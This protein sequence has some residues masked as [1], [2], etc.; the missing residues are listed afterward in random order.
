MVQRPWAAD[1]PAIRAPAALDLSA[2]PQDNPTTQ[3]LLYGRGRNYQAL[4][5]IAGMLAL[6]GSTPRDAIF[7]SLS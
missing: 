1:E 3:H 5:S 4:M 7:D 2:L 6:T